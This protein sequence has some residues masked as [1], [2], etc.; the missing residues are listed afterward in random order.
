MMVFE[1]LFNNLHKVLA[2]A[3]EV[4]VVDKAVSTWEI[5]CTIATT[6]AVILAVG[7]SAYS[8]RTAIISKRESTRMA[9]YLYL[10]NVWYDLK[11][12]EFEYPNF[13]D[14]NKTRSYKLFSK[15]NS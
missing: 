7:I 3:I 9:S 2:G 6:I 1:Q 12:K 15:V 4:E 11:Q 13:V 10:G 8:L 14:E 5:W